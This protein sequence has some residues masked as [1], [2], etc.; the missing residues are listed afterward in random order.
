MSRRTLTS[1]TESDGHWTGSLGAGLTHTL[2]RKWVRVAL[3]LLLCVAAAK[4]LEVF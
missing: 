3:T 1:L 2:P 4:Y